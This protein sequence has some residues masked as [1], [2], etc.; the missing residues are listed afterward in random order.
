[1]PPPPAPLRL[2]RAALGLAMRAV[3]RRHRFAVAV[4]AAGA[5][6]PLLRRLA[7]YQAW[8]VL[9][10]E[11]AHEIVLSRVLNAFDRILVEFDPE[12]RIEGE[13]LLHAAARRGRGVLV[14]GPHTM[15]TTLLLRHFHDR[16]VAQTVIAQKPSWRIAGTPVSVPTIQPSRTALLAARARLAKGDVVWAMID[17][18][19]ARGE[20]TVRFDTAVGQI[21]IDDSLIRVAVRSRA[22]VLFTA[23]RVE[24]RTVVIRI[25]APGTEASRSE[26]GITGAFIAFVQ[27]HVAR[28]AELRGR[29]RR[30]LAGAGGVV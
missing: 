21:L 24:G 29:V 10:V 25:A 7:V 15:L 13:E 28:A 4:H 23:A 16:G 5:V 30:A 20:R 3:P 11:S 14:I 12:P 22:P 17:K 18:K 8:G 27:D 19:R 26:A 1:M 6:A 9:R 2:G